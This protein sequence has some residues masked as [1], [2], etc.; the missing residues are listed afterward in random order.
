MFLQEEIHKLH[1]T[2]QKSFRIPKLTGQRH[3][4]E[5]NVYVGNM[6][7]IGIWKITLGVLTVM[8]KILCTLEIMGCH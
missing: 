1:Q 4:T 2:I 3:G 7:Q 6:P 8:V 5:I